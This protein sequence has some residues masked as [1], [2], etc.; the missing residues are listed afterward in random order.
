MRRACIALASLILVA[1]CSAASGDLAPAP[2][3]CF[4]AFDA[5]FAGYTS[6]TSYAYDADASTAGNVHFS[7][8]RVEYIEPLPP[9]GSTA[10]PVGTL[11]VKYISGINQDSHRVFAMAKR[12]CDFNAGGAKGWEF[13]ELTDTSPPTILWRG[14]APPAG[15]SYFGDPSGCN[16]CHA[17]CSDNDSVCSAK[18]RLGSD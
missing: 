14:T 7:G 8:P 10:F 15:E 1:A 13:F 12:G 2:E 9:H 6:W 5:Q 16:T 4:L 18:I 17:A 11:I 3:T